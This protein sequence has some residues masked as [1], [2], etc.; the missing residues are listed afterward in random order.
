MSLTT[1]S[2]DLEPDVISL[3]ILL[4]V[5]A[6]A[7][8]CGLLA[9]FTLPV[10]IAWKVLWLSL[11]VASGARDLWLI[12]SGYKRCSRLRL[13]HDGN[14]QAWSPDGHCAAAR[15]SAGSLVTTGFAWLRVELAGG[16]RLGLL[17]RRNAS[18]IKAW[19][20]L[21]VIWRHLGAGD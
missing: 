19:R 9:L 14:V 7:F 17:V 12:A 4:A 21:Q 18:E 2:T 15:L 6:S 10:G 16:R 3:F 1:Y 8:C 11:W 20:R 5:G 13:H